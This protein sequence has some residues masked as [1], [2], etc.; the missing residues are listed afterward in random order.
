MSAYPRSKASEVAGLILLAGSVLLALSLATYHSLDSSLNASSFRTEYVNAVGRLGAWISDLLFQFAGIPALLLPLPLLFLGYKMVRRRAVEHPF[1][2]AAAFATTVSSLSTGLSI[3]SISLSESVNFSAG[4]V[5]GIF[6]AETLQTYL[7]P[8]GALLVTATLL[9]LSLT[10]AT[11][12]SIDASL[13]RLERFRWT[14]QLNLR[15]RFAAWR[16]GRMN[17][18]ELRRL[19]QEKKSVVTQA[20]PRKIVLERSS[21]QADA[22]PGRRQEPEQEIEEE[23]VAPVVALPQRRGQKASPEWSSPHSVRPDSGKAFQLPSLDFL[24]Q[25]LAEA[26]I[27][28]E[29]LIERAQRLTEKCEEFDVRGRVIQIHP[30]PVVTTFEFKPDPGVKYSRITNLA[31]DLCLALRAESIRIDRI[32]GKNTVGIE[33]PNPERRVIFLREVLGSASFQQSDGRLTLALGQL[34]NGSNHCADLTRMPHLLIAGATG[35][36][37]SVGLNCMVCS[38]LYKATP[39]E[40]RFIMVDPKRLELGVYED[41]PHLLTPIVTDPKKAANALNWAVREMEERYRILARQGVRNID[42]FNQLVDSGGRADEPIEALE[43]LPLIVIIVDELADLIMTSGKEVEYALTRLAQMARAVGIHLILATQRPSVD[44]LT[45]L[46]KSNF[47]CRVSF[48]VSS[49]VD[50]RTI[51]DGN[52]AQQLLGMGDMLFLSPGTSRLVRI[53]GAYVSEKEIAGITRFLKSQSAPDYREEVLEETSEETGNEGA[54]LAVEDMEDDYYE[55]AARFVVETGR[56][57]TSLLQRR[58]RIGYGRAARLLDMMEHEGLVGSAEGTRPR[59]VL[60]S[61]DYFEQV[62]DVEDR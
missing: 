47:P 33:V 54:L 43:R 56:A 40:V 53:H 8:L 31:D 11:R 61:P 3:L 29:Q 49:K 21:A 34:I 48:R 20:L 16:L 57:S 14:P 19:R 9:L 35:T 51:L 27:N 44:V 46:I 28:E 50:S 36:G 7:N 62:G 13:R 5:L 6:L 59:D 52:G 18:K 38:I 4:G 1:L 32:P 58:F 37:K 23:A 15:A 45:G 25:P 12:L 17:R 10:A 39:R 22:V 41:I 42:Q 60:A 30:G 26:D 55:E 2:K 24:Q